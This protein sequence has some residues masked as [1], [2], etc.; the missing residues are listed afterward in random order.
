MPHGP[1]GLVSDA[2]TTQGSRQMALFHKHEKLSILH[3]GLL[4][5]GD[6]AGFACISMYV[7]MQ[8]G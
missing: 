4:L 6:V 3:C 7:A 1:G 2:A 5:G 8:S